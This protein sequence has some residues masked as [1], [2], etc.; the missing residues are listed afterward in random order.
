[1]KMIMYRGYGW[2][3]ELGRVGLHCLHEFVVGVQWIESGVLGVTDMYR[4]LGSP[5]GDGQGDMYV[6]SLAAILCGW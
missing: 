2:G 3:W 4:A 1:M 6:Q 5:G